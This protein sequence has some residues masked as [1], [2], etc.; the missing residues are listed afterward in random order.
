MTVFNS[1]ELIKLVNN[2]LNHD[3]LIFGSGIFFDEDTNPFNS[4]LAYVYSFRSGDSI[5][6]QVVDDNTDQIRYDY[7]KD[8]PEWWRIPA[9]DNR[10]GWTH[11]YYDTLSGRPRMITYFYPFFFDDVFSG[12]TTIDIS[13]D[14]FEK[15]LIK[16]H[17][18][19]QKN[20]ETTTFII[21][22]DSTIILSDQRN[23]IGKKVF[24]SNPSNKYRFN[25]E[26]SINVLNK[27][28]AGKTGMD[29]ISSFDGNKKFIAFFSP[30]H[31]TEWSI[32]SLI[33]YELIN[34][35][36]RKNTFDV[37]LLI[38]IFN[39]VLILI[40]ILIARYITK[41]ITKLSKLSLKIAN[42]DY[43][44]TI[45]IYS[46]DEIGLLS[47]N[48]KLMKNNLRKR[49]KEITEANKKYEIIFDNSPIGIVYF[50]KNSKILSY[51]KR[52]LEIN[53]LDGNE[54]YVGKAA[55]VL[56]VNDKNKNILKA[57]IN[58]GKHGSYT[59]E[60]SYVPGMYVRVNV[61]PVFGSEEKT[62]GAIAT[63]E[64]ITT[65]IRNTKLQI[66][67][68]AAEKA[69]E[70]KS[71]FLAN[72]SHEIRTPM[73]AIIG[74]SHLMGKTKLDNKQQD[75]L[76]KIS[77]SANLLL[78]VINDILDFSKIEAGKIELESAWFNLEE[79]LNDLNNLFTYSANQKNLEFIL[80][81]D[82]DVPLRLLG[83]ELRLKQVLINFLS[84]SMKFTQEG[85][86]EVLLKI[87][88]RKEDKCILQFEVRDTG[89]GMSKE[90]QDKVF[91]AFSQADESTTRK[92][93]GTGLGLSI[94]KR[95]VEM[96][97]GQIWV[98]SREG[99]GTTFFFTAGFVCE[100]NEKGV[101]YYIPTPDL[102]NIK[103]YVCDDNATT[104]MVISN[105]LKAF[106]FVPEAF[107]NGESLLKH[108]EST[109][110]ETA[111][112]LI[113][114][115]QMPGMN[116]LEVARL[117][118]QSNKIKHKPKIILL[119]A[120]SNVDFEK[121]MEKGSIGAV[122]YKPVSYSILFD[123]IMNVFNKDIPL[124]Q[125]KGKSKE[126]NLKSLTPFAG[127]HVLLVDDNEINQ[128][129]AAELLESFGLSV[130]VA[131]NGK[132]AVEKVLNSEPSKYNLVF[133][134]L[135]M[136]VMDGYTATKTL[137]KN[138]K[139]HD[140]PIVAMTADVMEG[141]KEECLKIG[142]KDFVSKPINPSEVVKAIINWAVKPENA[143][144]TKKRKKIESAN[145]DFDF[146]KLR[147][148]DFNEG[149]CRVNGNKMTYIKILK[150]FSDNYSKIAEQLL[151]DV[152]AKDAETI[153]SKLHSLKGVAGNI[154]AN[155]LH[156]L[157]KQTE[158]E[159]KNG[160]PNNS[161][162]LLTKIDEAL[163]SIL[164]SIK[165]AD[166]QSGTN[167]ETLDEFVLS[168]TVIEKIKKAIKL[169]DDSDPDGIEL[170]E[171]INFS[172]KYKNIKNKIKKSLDNYDFETA[173][174]I[175]TNIVDI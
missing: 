102:R 83:D 17:M 112:L 144:R 146:T 152:K 156:E 148:I 124:R 160:I 63:I 107:E 96:M 67:A 109:T 120:F 130:D 94:S 164:I 42:G 68:E 27:T 158:R 14:V 142:M 56:I 1:D 171:E 168:D 173:K 49:E 84:N 123:T 92:Y 36:V 98:E 150:K 161:K 175:L 66:K 117:I 51:N 52:F 132:I 128:D 116:G 37:F 119:T 97:G 60:S 135:Q 77:S 53:N 76:A 174:E 110:Y 3:E 139:Y 10:S 172:G 65:E 18:S 91:E 115:W 162:L 85:E 82:S 118:K 50:D 140:V 75:Y 55:G 59:T 134:D 71:L 99:V 72:M 137:R 28:F 145:P 121:T 44:E 23:N 81:I 24:S 57:V 45:S 2:N 78:G 31:S 7:I 147:N 122:L 20:F 15:W 104:R 6:M 169:L 136:P 129:V 131:G 108:L 101:G 46:N 8:Y 87:V 29:K 39:F 153:K 166:I 58:E 43:S 33:P 30:I 143:D 89:I 80:H 106:T 19:M 11:P 47:N 25:A 141:V 88:D 167:K 73:N 111:N 100:E 13:L 155:E 54:S 90:Q 151:T 61:E 62:T 157:L 138:K 48:F 35:K 93:G 9:D 103:A 126:L 154:G 95:L 40:I 74:L 16:E 69:N 105:M 41:P 170:I 159:F 165:D 12:I 21:S 22:K 114:D 38:I 149:L 133:M 113:L 125:K 5:S 64:D 4:R 127:A 70:S 34:E 163:Q 86:I 32:I 26:Q 79:M